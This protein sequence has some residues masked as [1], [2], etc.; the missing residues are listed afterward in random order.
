MNTPEHL[1]HASV[2]GKQ[3]VCLLRRSSPRTKQLWMETQLRMMQTRDGQ[4]DGGTDVDVDRM[5]HT[6][7]RSPH[8]HHIPPDADGPRTHRPPRHIHQAAG[9]SLL[10]YLGTNTHSATFIQDQQQL[11][12]TEVLSASSASVIGQ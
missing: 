12:G 9:R 1:R 6:E 5:E 10:F 2:H 7:S 4:R 8:I 3:I 11:G